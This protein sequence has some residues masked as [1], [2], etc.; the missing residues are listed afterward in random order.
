MGS[1]C[2]P[3]FNSRAREGRDARRHDPGVFPC[4]S[5]HAPAR[6]A[7]PLGYRLGRRKS[8]NSRARE[9]RDIR[10]SLEQLK[11]VV[12]IHAPARGATASVPCIRLA[13]LFQFTRPRGARHNGRPQR[14]QLRC[15]NSRAREGRDSNETLNTVSELFQFTRP[16]GARQAIG[17][18]ASD[19]MQ[20]QFTRPRGARQQAHA[21]RWSRRRFNSRARE[22]RDGKPARHCKPCGVSIHAP[23]R[24]ATPAIRM[25]QV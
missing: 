16:R 12:S 4:V 14:G 19:N 8:F 23:A 5:I 1:F 10:S 24:G 18:D 2:T 25:V 11:A 6:G 21:C 9:G 15:F 20:F 22:G 7:T 13:H 17:G 3:C